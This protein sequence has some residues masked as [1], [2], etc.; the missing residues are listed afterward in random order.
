M[1]SKN[2][3]VIQDINKDCNGVCVTH[4]IRV[5]SAADVDTLKSGSYTE[6]CL[7]AL[8]CVSDAQS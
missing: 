1:E 4:M 6:L 8:W 5:R 2:E 3:K 7:E